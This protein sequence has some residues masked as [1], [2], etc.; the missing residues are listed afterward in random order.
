NV[1][2]MRAREG[3]LGANVLGDEELIA[4]AID[5]SGSD[6]AMLDNAVELLVHGG[7]SLPHALAMLIPEA[8]EGFVDLDPALR[9]FYRHSACLSG[10]PR[11]RGSGCT[12]GGRGAVSRCRRRGRTW[13]GTGSRSASPRK[14]SPWCSGPWP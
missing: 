6:S 10:G 11:G 9:A 8:W 4:P 2:L 7:R 3:H 14:R 1:N 13:C 5:E 12:C